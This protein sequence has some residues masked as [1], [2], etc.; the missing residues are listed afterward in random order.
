MFTDNGIA[1]FMSNHHEKVSWKHALGLIF[2]KHNYH[3]FNAEIKPK[4]DH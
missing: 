4:L 2:L 3:S 1:N